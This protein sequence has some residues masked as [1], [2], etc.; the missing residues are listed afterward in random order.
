MSEIRPG[1]P[2]SP[3]RRVDVWLSRRA[4]LVGCVAAY[5]V[6]L[7]LLVRAWANDPHFL[8][9]GRDGVLALWLLRTNAEWGSPWSLT[10]LNPF[11]GMGSMLL[12]LNPWWVP[13]SLF[14]VRGPGS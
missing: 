9:T 7:G 4:W 14:S 6:L 11:Q 1:R 10:L 2:A 13:A 5:L 12:P 3:E 8:Y